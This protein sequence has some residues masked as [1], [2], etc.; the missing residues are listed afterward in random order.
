[1]GVR[2]SI[3]DE[4]SPSQKRF[5]INTSEQYP[6][7]RLVETTQ[8]PGALKE[9]PFNGIQTARNIVKE[10]LGL[11]DSHI[12][13]DFANKE[14]F[15]DEEQSLSYP[16]LRT[17]YRKE[18]FEGTVTTMDPNTLD[19]IGAKRWDH[20]QVEDSHGS[21]EGSHGWKKNSV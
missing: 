2:I 4:G 12:E 8:L 1:M 19:L 7:G 11:A 3:K 13:F 9:P 21:F 18:I 10:H 16:G 5:L 6:D 17:V 14:Y 15:E 20:W